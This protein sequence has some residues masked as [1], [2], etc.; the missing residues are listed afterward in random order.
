VLDASRF[1]LEVGDVDLLIAIGGGSVIDL[2]KLVSVFI[3]NDIT[4]PKDFERIRMR[5]HPEGGFEAATVVEP[6]LRIV[7][8]PTT[9]SGA[10]FTAVA[11]VTDET[12]KEKHGY[13]HH[14]MAPATVVLDPAITLHT[15]EW[16]WLSTGMRAVDHCAETLASLRSNPIC[17]GN[18]ATGLRLLRSGLPAVCL[19]PLDLEARL[20]CQLGAWQAI[21]PLAA[22]VPMGLSHAIGHALGG[23]CNVPHGYTSCVM[24]PYVMEWNLEAN[25]DRQALISACFDA[26]ER[27]ASQLIGAFIRELG[28]PRT[29]SEVGVDADALATV[30]RHTVD[31][32]FGRANPRPI[33]S[34]ADVLQV[35]R[36]ALIGDAKSDDVV[37]PR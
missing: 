26:P 35:L 36:R 21:L 2:T 32:V 23:T 28:L 17:D 31:D 34:T 8:V 16:T 11:G 6:H 33:H 19:N 1:V 29:L 20:Q 30:A 24:L 14:L 10:E 3:A 15:P 25:R 18:A 27:P 4:A 37:V 22:G 9:L 13:T 7:C 12:T 5:A